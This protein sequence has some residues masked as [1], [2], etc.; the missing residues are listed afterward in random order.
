MQTG[1]VQAAFPSLHQLFDW[2][3]DLVQELEKGAE[4]TVH[5]RHSEKLREK[6]TGLVER[7]PADMQERFDPELM[8]VGYSNY[9]SF[10]KTSTELKGRDSELRP[11]EIYF[12]WYKFKIFSRNFYILSSDT[13]SQV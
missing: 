8:L 10:L 5:G 4:A 11:E 13:S 9:S 6:L 12:L 3:E 7:L 2:E 1:L